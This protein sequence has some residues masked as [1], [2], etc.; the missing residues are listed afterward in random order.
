MKWLESRIRLQ[1]NPTR[2]DIKIEPMT[3]DELDE[4]TK[5]LRFPKI[6]VTEI[7]VVKSITQT[8]MIGKKK[9]QNRSITL[10]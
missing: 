7:P 3:Q 2:L 9:N 5:I 6:I 1:K 4:L 10:D 8:K